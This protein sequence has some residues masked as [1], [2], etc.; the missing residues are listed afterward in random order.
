M[1]QQPS[2][3]KDIVREGYDRIAPR[4]G[5]WI[6][7]ARSAER[8]RYTQLL[9][10]ELPAGAAV[11][12]LGCGS[13]EPT[14]RRLAER[15]RVTGVDISATQIALARQ[16]APDVCFI[17][18]DMTQLEFPPCSFDGVAAFYSLI[19]VPREE[20]AGLLRDM[21]MWLRPG[22]LL[23]AAMGAHAAEAS[24]EED[25]LG[26][27]MYWSGFDGETNRRLVEET[28]LNVV[29]ATYETE[30]EFGQPVNFLWV[31]A[32]KPTPTKG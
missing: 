25:F 14:T 6:I 9:L 4:H 30:E 22:G 11:L 26:T 12:D 8:A 2:D 32:R 13:G 18:A 31:V 19:H 21:A 10:D 3:P 28:G 24:Y 29:S 23:A 1:S 17:Q 16:A 5:E 27:Q 7:E 15:F 20:Q